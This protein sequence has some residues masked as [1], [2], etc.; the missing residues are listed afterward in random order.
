MSTIKP[1]DPQCKQSGHKWREHSKLQGQS[2]CLNCGVKAYCPDC[3]LFIPE[4]AQIRYCSA[5]LKERTTR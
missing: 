1:H 4:R 2:Y 5:H 3:V